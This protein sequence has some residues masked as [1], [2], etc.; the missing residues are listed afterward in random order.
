MPTATK[1][2]HWVLS[3]KA[4]QKQTISGVK[5]TTTYLQCDSVFNQQTN[6]NIHSVERL[7]KLIVFF[8]TLNNSLLELL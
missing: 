1:F 2:I 4:S 5:L 6:F 7:F 3:Y 8:D